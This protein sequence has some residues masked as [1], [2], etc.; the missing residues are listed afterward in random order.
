MHGKLVTLLWEYGLS[1]RG[2]GAIILIKWI[3]S[4][5]D[6]IRFGSTRG[7]IGY[8]LFEFDWAFL[9]DQ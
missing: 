3:D 6:R 4:I 8:V 1:A 5:T 7:R 9:G 2:T